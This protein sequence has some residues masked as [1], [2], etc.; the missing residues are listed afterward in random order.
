MLFAYQPLVSSRIR[1]PVRYE[2]LLRIRA[3]NGRVVPATNF[4]SV[5]K[6]RGMIWPVD[7]LAL[8]L[9]VAELERDPVTRLALNVS[10]LTTTDRSWLRAAVV[11][12]RPRPLIAERLVIKITETAGLGIFPSGFRDPRTSSWFN[13]STAIRSIEGSSPVSIA[14]TMTLRT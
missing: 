3:T 10:R 8:D 9:A 4:M 14:M 11:M 7:R 2:C 13:G 5:V 1:E 6:Q 12:L